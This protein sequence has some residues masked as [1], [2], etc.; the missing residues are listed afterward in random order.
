MP[1]QNNRRIKNTIEKRI[2]IKRRI[3]IENNKNNHNQFIK[4]P[5]LKP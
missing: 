2:F 3:N 5:K 4:N 1:T